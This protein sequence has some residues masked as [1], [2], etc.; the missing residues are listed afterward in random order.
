MGGTIQFTL[1]TPLASHKNSLTFGA[2]Y[3]YG[4]T[5]FKQSA[6]DAVFDSTRQVVGV[7]PYALATDVNSTTAYTGLYFTDTFALHRAASA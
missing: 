2:S 1:L 5:S 6:Q 4:S 3:D 7:T